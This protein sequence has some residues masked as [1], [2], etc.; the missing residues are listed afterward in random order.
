MIWGAESAPSLAARCQ[1]SFMPTAFTQTTAPTFWRVAVTSAS[2]NMRARPP[3]PTQSA[4]NRVSPSAA[5]TWMSP[6]NRMTYR[7]LRLS[8][9]SN[10]LTSPKPR[11][12][13]IVTATPSGRS[14]FSRDRHRSS[15]SLRWFFSSSLSTVSQRRGMALPWRVTRC[16]ASG[17]LVV[18]VEVGPVHR[19]DDLAPLAHHL[20]NPRGEHVPGDHARVA[21]QAVDLFDRGLGEQ[22][23]CLRERLPDQRNRERR[24]GHH[25]ERSVGQRQHALG[26]QVV[27]EHPLQELMNE[28]K[29]LLR[30]SHRSP[31]PLILHS[32]TGGLPHSGF[33]ESH[34]NEGIHE[35]GSLPWILAVQS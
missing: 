1:A 2:R 28:I 22:S 11:S 20:A 16:S 27:D 5:L 13:R 30:R 10:S 4:A 21:Q 31:G 8:R 34:K 35:S 24:P 7:N 33:F 19:H 18:G 6:R 12:A 32:G 25:P 3:L 9:N 15:K 17:G 29:S 26:V 14:A 23:A